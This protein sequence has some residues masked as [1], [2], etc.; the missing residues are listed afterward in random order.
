MYQMKWGLVRRRTSLR[1]PSS[2][3]NP[4]QALR[5]SRPCR[6]SWA[7]NM[8]PVSSMMHYHA[9]FD[10]RVTFRAGQVLAGNSCGVWSEILVCWELRN[11]RKSSNWG[12]VLRWFETSCTESCYGP[13]SGL[14]MSHLVGCFFNRLLEHHA[15]FFLEVLL[16]EQRLL[17][18]RLCAR[19]LCL[20][21]TKRA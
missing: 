1:G 8:L 14:G 21:I 9:S 4:T 16:L 12:R 3:T 20:C 17:N 10:W 19:T 2:S 6:A 5:D 11:R 15:T 18:V 7:F 13:V